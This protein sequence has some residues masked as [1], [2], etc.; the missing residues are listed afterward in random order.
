MPKFKDRTGKRFN[1]LLVI[2]RAENNK[3]GQVQWN[4]LCDCGKVKVICGGSLS[5]GKSQSCG[6]LIAE[7]N[8]EL[9]TTHGLTNSPEYF[10]WDGMRQRCGNPNHKAFQHYGGRGI[11]V[12]RRWAL[13]GNFFS[14]MGERPGKKYWI[15]RIDND[16]NYSPTNCKWETTSKQAQNKRISRRNTSGVAGVSWMVREGKW[17]ARIGAVGVA[18]SLGYYRRFEDA[19]A[20]RKAGERKYWGK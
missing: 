15:E 4:C 14:D 9:N 7:R 19:V 3:W 1:R 12:C 11:Q 5:A 16:G 17:A 6:C 20:A 18:V 10:V 8:I 13:F 2:S